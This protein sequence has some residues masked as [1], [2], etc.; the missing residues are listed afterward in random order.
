MNVPGRYG[1]CQ[2][3][4]LCSCPEPNF[5]HANKQ[6]STKQRLS[7]NLI[8]PILFEHSQLGHTNDTMLEMKDTTYD[9]IDQIF[10][11]RIW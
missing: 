6:E 11:R 7:F 2:D 9:Y 1:I 10:E 4:Q 3:E 5:F 8:T